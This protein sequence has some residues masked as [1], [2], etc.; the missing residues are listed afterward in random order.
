M[1]QE[2]LLTN[3]TDI[4]TATG[5]KF[6]IS[7]KFA[8]IMFNG[9]SYRISLKQVIRPTF[10]GWLKTVKD[11]KRITEDLPKNW[12]ADHKENIE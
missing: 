3:A 6:L 10:D 8:N 12:I 9:I 5:E 7:G 11:Q 2:E 4:L 1:T